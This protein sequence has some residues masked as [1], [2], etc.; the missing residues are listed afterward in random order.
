MAALPDTGALKFA[1]VFYLNSDVRHK[2][3]IEDDRW[4]IKDKTIVN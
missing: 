1:E 3:K 2:L 4:K